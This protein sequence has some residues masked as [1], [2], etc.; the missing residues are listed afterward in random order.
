M[1]FLLDE[2]IDTRLTAFLTDLGHDA[3][4]IA[5][6]YPASLTD[7]EVLAIA[8]REQR[9]LITN[10]RDFGELVFIQ[11][12]PHA[13]IIYLRV[14]PATFPVQRE[15]LARV[16]RSHADQL[17]EFLVVTSASVRVRRHRPT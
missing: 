5:R 1:R 9:I 2:N 7:L 16:L 3:T 6:D 14:R 13:G 12:Q 10:D 15:R 8:Q 4:A 11:A 17:H